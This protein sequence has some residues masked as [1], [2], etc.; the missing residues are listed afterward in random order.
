MQNVVFNFICIII[1]IENRSMENTIV[2]HFSQYS[3]V[4]LAF[5]IGKLKL[6]NFVVVYLYL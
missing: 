6:L 3:Q 4:Q 5:S 2:M 1:Y